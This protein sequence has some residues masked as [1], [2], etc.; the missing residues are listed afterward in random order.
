MKTFIRLLIV[1]IFLVIIASSIY[2]SLRDNQR[3]PTPQLNVQKTAEELARALEGISKE[4]ITKDLIEKLNDAP[5]KYTSLSD[6]FVVDFPS[7]PQRNTIEN[8]MGGTVKNYQSVSQDGLV[9]YNVFF[10]YFDKKILS[11]ESQEAYLNSHLT[12]RLLSSKN[13]HGAL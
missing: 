8:V 13:S 2:F 4:D 7:T 5:T 12:G 9:G 11:D 1:I 6:G 3:Q 10:N